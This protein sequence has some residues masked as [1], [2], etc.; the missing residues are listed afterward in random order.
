M[1]DADDE[2]RILVVAAGAGDRSA[3]EHLVGRHKDSLY[4]LARRYLADGDEAYDILQ[5]TF[6]AAWLNLKRFDASRSWISWLRAIL[7]NKCRDHTR[8]STVR[9]RTLALFAFEWP[10]HQEPAEEREEER[11]SREQRR[12]QELD[13]AIAALP[14]RYKE[15]LLLTLTSGLTQPEAARQLGITVKA[16]ELRARRARQRLAR[17]MKHFETVS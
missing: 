11:E 2:D 10:K 12:L 16:V 17:I 5:E 1:S 13:R 3:F 15:P 7:L 6:V 9:N 4:R 14:P 8:R